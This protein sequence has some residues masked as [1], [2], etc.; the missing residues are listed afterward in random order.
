[1]ETV[2]R[3]AIA[4]A[5]FAMTQTGAAHAAVQY[6]EN[7]GVDS[8]SCAFASPCRTISRA[9]TNASAGDTIIVGPGRYGDIDGDN[10]FTTSG[11]EAAEIG[12]GCNCVLKVDKIHASTR[13]V[14]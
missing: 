9:V 1:M 12:S 4:I 14:R 6:V 7:Y 11:D 10:A 5:I 3:R 8:A 13:Q 2:I